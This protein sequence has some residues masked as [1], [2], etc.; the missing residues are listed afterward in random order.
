MDGGVEEAVLSE[1]KDK[2]KSLSELIP[3]RK[4]ILVGAVGLEPTTP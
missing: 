2:H 1:T 3:L 4:F